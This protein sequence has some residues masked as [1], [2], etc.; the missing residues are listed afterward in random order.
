L[1][2]SDILAVI[3]VNPLMD[4]TSLINSDRVNEGDV[5]LL[6]EGIY[7]Q[8]VAVLKNNIR[9]VAKGPGVIFDGKSTLLDAFLL[10]DV[11]GVMIEGIT[12]RHYRA[13]GILIEFGFGHRIVNNKIINM[14]ENGVEVM[15]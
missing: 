13:S 9:I 15:S 7:F 6:E 4:I 14:I 3:N 2:G 12:I 11:V 5:L 1:K 8:S 10:P